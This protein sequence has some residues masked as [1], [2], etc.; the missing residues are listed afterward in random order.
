MRWPETITA[1]KRNAD[2]STRAAA[3]WLVQRFAAMARSTARA[4]FR[5]SSQ[6]KG[7]CT[8]RNLGRCSQSK[9]LAESIRR[10]QAVPHVVRSIHGVRSEISV[11]I[12]ARFVR[13]R[14]A[15][16]I[17]NAKTLISTS[18]TVETRRL[19]RL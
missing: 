14:R 2:A 9:L 10:V 16:Q 13:A 18:A 1:V 11:R 8:K 3:T 5:H 19:K 17:A 7:S 12:S 6:R 15:N 4:A